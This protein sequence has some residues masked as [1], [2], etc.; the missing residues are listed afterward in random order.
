[1][2]V[3]DLDR[4]AIQQAITVLRQEIATTSDPAQ[5]HQ[6]ERDLRAFLRRWIALA[7]PQ[8]QPSLASTQRYR[9]H[10]LSPDALSN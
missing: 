7:A 3:P 1:M 9:R 8:G 10:Q 6:L 2:F 5:Q 4:A